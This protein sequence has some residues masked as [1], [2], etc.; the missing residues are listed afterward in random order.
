MDWRDIHNYMMGFWMIFRPTKIRRIT[1]RRIRTDYLT[2]DRWSQ[3]LV[4]RLAAPQDSR[5]INSSGITRRRIPTRLP[6]SKLIA[7][8]AACSPNSLGCDRTVVSTT[9]PGNL[10]Y[11]EFSYI[12]I[13]G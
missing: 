4:C 1:Y 7:A 6:S 10:Y 2:F 12:F 8:R 11:P 5:T 3:V 13:G 9:T